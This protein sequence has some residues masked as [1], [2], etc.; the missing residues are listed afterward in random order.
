MGSLGIG[1]PLFGK[2]ALVTGGSRGIGRA[3][4]LELACQGAKVAVNY[5][6]SESAA[7][8]VVDIIKVNGGE[9]IA[10]QAD[11]SDSASAVSLVKRTVEELGGLDILVNNAGIIRDGL[12]MRM[13]EGDWD[14]VQNTDLRGPFLI[15]KAACRPLLR[16]KAGRIINIGSVIGITGNPGQANYAAAKAGLI[17]F[18]RAVA[19]EL[20]TRF[21]TANVIAP[22]FIDT[23]IIEVMKAEAIEATLKQ[24]PFG[25]MGTPEE[26]APL[27]A[28]LA[29]DAASY[30]T[31]QVFNV[32]GGMVMA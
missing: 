13:S 29:S 8:T 16:S 6:S 27:V 23:R 7:T 26:V 12:L 10:L 17:G 18:T 20:A 21:I 15:T 2:T 4:A 28:F 5:L 1:Q 25:R 22:G 9:A 31:G 11:V 32:D 24:I 14:A 3:I 19:R 30:I